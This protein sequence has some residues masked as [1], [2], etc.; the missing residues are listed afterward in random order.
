[1]TAAAI[2]DRVMK[3]DG[4]FSASLDPRL[5]LRFVSRVSMSRGHNLCGGVH[6]GFHPVSGRHRGV[7]RE[8]STRRFFQQS[9]S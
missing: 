8:I 7:R 5:V 3:A 2:V 6:G 9:Q 1:M 4:S